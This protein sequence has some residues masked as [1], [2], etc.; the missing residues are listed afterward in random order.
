MKKIEKYKFEKYKNKII[1]FVILT[2]IIILITIMILIL[3]NININS[4]IIQYEAKRV[5]QTNQNKEEEF[6]E[7]KNNIDEK[8]NIKKEIVENVN[9]KIES[10]QNNN[11][12]MVSK[13]GGYNVIARLDIPK[14]NLQTYVL[15]EYSKEALLV[16]VTKFWGGNP[17]EVGNFCIAG[18]NYITKNM[19][20]NVR[21]LEIGDEIYLTDNQNRKIKYEIYDV[22]KV[23][24]EDTRVCISKNQWKKGDYSNYLYI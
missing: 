15:S 24:P 7:I 3:N 21:K 6:L 11:G 18:H 22:F 1:I 13:Y 16:S 14:I 23:E 2:L 12:E 10:N 4:K 17:N 20:H 5:N 19:F 9:Q 8:E